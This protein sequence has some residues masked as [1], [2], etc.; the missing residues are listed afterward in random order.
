M[1]KKVAYKGYWVYED[2]TIEGKN[3]IRKISIRPDGYL[4]LTMMDP[5]NYRKRV[6]YMHHRFVWEAF[7]GPA[8]DDMHVDHIDQTRTNNHLSNLRLVTRLEN[9]NNRGGKFSK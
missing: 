3:G 2:G 6:N 5:M 1:M 9:N 7:N 8:P 4:Q